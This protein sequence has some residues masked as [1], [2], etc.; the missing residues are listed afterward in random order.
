MTARISRFA[1]ALLLAA[2]ATARA[3]TASLHLRDDV[4]PPALHSA[5][6]KSTQKSATFVADTGN[7]AV[8][9][10]DGG[11]ERGNSAPRF[12][13]AQRFYETHADDFDFLVVFSTFEF[14]TGDALAFYNPV[15]NDVQGIGIEQF[16]A[17]ASY[18]SAGRL[19]GYIDMASMARYDFNSHSPDYRSALNTLAHEIMHRWSVRLRYHDAGGAARSDLLGREGA[20]WSLYASTD[21]S[22]MYGARWNQAQPGTWTVSEARQRLGPWDLYLAGLADAA[23]MP[24]IGLIR[25]TDYPASDLPRVGLSVQGAQ[26]I[27]APAQVFAAEGPRLPA[28]SQSQRRFDAALVLLV[29][30][31]QTPDPADLARL[32]RFRVAFEQYFQGITGGR[33]TL[34]LHL[35]PRSTL[36]VSDPALLPASVVSPRPEPVNAALQWLRTQQRGNG[37]WE[38]RPGTAVRDTASVLAALAEIAPQDPGQAVARQWLAARGARNFDE[39]GWLQLAQPEAPASLASL[40]GDGGLGLQAAW[41]SSPAEICSPESLMV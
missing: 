30:P 1:F 41:N 6:A 15:R 3:D 37:R 33:A 18:G 17:S 14:P 20:H 36:A 32:E 11:Y 19:Q 16:D 34:R 10:L 22:L 28:A 25:S 40:N 4:E 29:R 2:G 13:L 9:R 21:A 23:E 5:P 24:D 12:E 39:S 26:E 31:G 35:Q 8:F 27:I 7:V 38:D